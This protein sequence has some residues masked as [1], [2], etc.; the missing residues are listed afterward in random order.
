M[1][2]VTIFPLSKRKPIYGVG[3]NDAWYVVQPIINGKKAWCLYYNTWKHMIKRCCCDK[4]QEKYP[5][6]IGCSVVKDWLTFSVFR[7]WMEQ[8]GWQ[9]KQ[10]DKDILVPVNKEY[11]PNTCI[12]VSGS[13]NNL[14]TDSA[15]SRGDCPQGVSFNKQ[16]GKYQSECRVNGKSKYLGRFPTAQEA[17]YAYLSFKSG[18]IRQI[19][20]EDEA[21]NFPKLQSALLRHAE[22]FA[23]KARNLKDLL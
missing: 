7:S 11:G 8:Q 14:L 17:A 23:K 12:F 6:Y 10:L 15:A 16:S 9:G 21:S 18:L 3:I 4:Y 20:Y 5:T 19:A 13:I 2:S 1:T 22:L